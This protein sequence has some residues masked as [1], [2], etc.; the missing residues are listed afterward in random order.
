MINTSPTKDAQVGD[1]SRTMVRH[2]GYRL[3][4]LDP[5]RR[6]PGDLS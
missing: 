2:L 3:T 6:K 4:P 5:M 1:K